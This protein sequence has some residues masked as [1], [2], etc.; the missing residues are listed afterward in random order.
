MLRLAF[1]QHWNTMVPQIFASHV[2]TTGALY[3]LMACS[4]HP[5]VPVLGGG[6]LASSEWSDALACCSRRMTGRSSANLSW[7]TTSIL[8][9]AMWQTQQ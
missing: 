2:W 7:A 1:A 3:A 8:H 5:K 6:S 9:M 4:N